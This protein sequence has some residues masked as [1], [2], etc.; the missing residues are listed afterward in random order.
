MQGYCQSLR[1]RRKLWLSGF[2]GN[3]YWR[4]VKLKAII[5]VAGMGTRLLPATKSIPKELLPIVD[6]PLIHYIV[7]ELI[8]AG[9]SEIVL[10]THS[11][12]QAVEDYFD[13]NFEIEQALSFNSKYK[14]LELLRS[15]QFDN[16]KVMSVRQAEPLGLGHAILCAEP[17]IGQESFA[18]ILP[19]VLIDD[20]SCQ[21]NKDNLATMIKNHEATGKGQIM[22]HPV[23]EELV[24]QFGIADIK[25]VDLKEGESANLNLVIEKPLKNDAPSNL[26]ITGRYVFSPTLWTK[27]SSTKA[28]SGGE[29]QL[30]DAV[31]SMLNESQT[32]DAYHLVGKTFDCGSKLGLATANY[33]FAKRHSV[34]G[35]EFVKYLKNSG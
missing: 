15:M 20:N 12:K 11:S 9:V 33:E 7:E 27:L 18:V 30:T 14:D 32:F 22:V 31:Q 24:D 26:S 23:P 21:L 16:L 29:I 17:I 2:W 1:E 35:R 5:P 4:G 28:G 13:S 34:I 10:V 8:S 6:K 25:G 19:D 3:H